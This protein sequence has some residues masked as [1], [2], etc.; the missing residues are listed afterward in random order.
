AAFGPGGLV[1]DLTGVA[2]EAAVGE[3]AESEVGIGDAEGADATLVLGKLRDVGA[4]IAKLR[5]VTALSALRCGAHNVDDGV[6]DEGRSLNPGV[7]DRVILGLHGGTRNIGEQVLSVVAGLMDVAIDV[8]T[9]VE[10]ILSAENLVDAADV[11]VE[12]LDGGKTVGDASVG[13]SLRDGQ[14]L[15]EGH[16]YGTDRNLVIGEG[17]AG[18]R[19]VDLDYLALRID[20]GA[21]VQVIGEISSEVRGGRENSVVGIALRTDARALI[22][23]EDKHAVLLDGAADGAAVLVALQGI[24]GGGE[25]VASIEGPVADEFESVAVP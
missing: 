18:S 22:S 12:V 6:V 25:E 5:H 10:F 15:G 9:A 8:E 13:E 23:E 17:I 1:A 7:A 11:L 20:A 16:G 19:V 24:L 4:E 21:G 3:V 14:Q 2:D